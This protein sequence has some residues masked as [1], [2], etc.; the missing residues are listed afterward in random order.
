VEGSSSS[1]SLSIMTTAETLV[2]SEPTGVPKVHLC[3]RHHRDKCAPKTSGFYNRRASGRNR[4]HVRK[5]P[6]ESPLW[7]CAINNESAGYLLYVDKAIA[8]GRSRHAP[9]KL[10]DADVPKHEDTG[11]TGNLTNRLHP[12]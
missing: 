11:I 7:S 8:N 3:I 1:A 4:N 12:M 5:I 10:R 6:L 2:P 9:Q